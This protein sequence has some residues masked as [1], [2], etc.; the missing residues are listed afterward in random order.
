MAASVSSAGSASSSR[1]TPR[2]RRVPT[3]TPPIAP[4]PVYTRTWFDVGAHFDGAE[5]ARAASSE[6]WA[7]DPDAWH[8]DG[9]L[10]PA[11]L[12]AAALREASRARRARPLRQEVFAE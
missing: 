6:A 12:D 5:L 1:S 4:A 7:G 9:P 2:R 8:L 11:G 10:L 3:T